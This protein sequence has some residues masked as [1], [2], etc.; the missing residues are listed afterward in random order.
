MGYRYPKLSNLLAFEKTGDGY[1]VSNYLSG[2]RYYFSRRVARFAML[3]DGKRDPCRIPC[4]L[5]REEVDQALAFLRREGLLRRSRFLRASPGTYCWTVF[6][7]GRGKRPRIAASLFNGALLALF[8]PVFVLGVWLFFRDPPSLHDGHVFPGCLL[9]ILT[10]LSLHELSHAA[11][12]LAYGGRVFEMGL[13]CRWLLPGAYVFMDAGPVE[14]NLK[15]AQINGAGIEC[16]LLLTGL[17]LLLSAGSEGYSALLLFA[18]MSN[19][20]LALM[21]LLLVKGLDGCGVISELLGM[22]DMDETPL[23]FPGRGEEMNPE[24]RAVCR[25]TALIQ[26]ALAVLIAINVMEVILWIM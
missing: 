17:F 15:Q 12:C 21:N 20:E 8:L 10:G 22:D 25:V 9:G 16:N 3:L 14:D 23:L 7:P 6:T 4:A 24:R 26:P 18:A 5:S 13:L 19:F 1:T 11:A 2:D